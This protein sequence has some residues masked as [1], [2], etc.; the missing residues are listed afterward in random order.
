M[1]SETTPAS[2]LAEEAEDIGSNISANLTMGDIIVQRMSR[3]DLVSG[4]LAVTAATLIA[5]PGAVSAATGQALTN[6]T[7]NFNFPELA[8]GCDEDHHVAEGYDADVLISWGDAV[9]P[10]APPFDPANASPQGQARQFGYNNDFLGFIPLDGRSDHGLLVAN[11]EY[12]NAELMFPGLPEKESR[13]A[14]WERIT[15]NQVDTEMMA[16]GGSI[17]EIQRTDGKW[18]LV[19]QSKYARRITA[20]TPMRIS[21]PAAG[22]DKMKTSTDPSGASVQ[23]MLNNCSGALTPWGT[24][25]TCEENFNG[26]FWGKAQLDKAEA[27]V[28]LK[29]YGIPGEFYRWAKFHDRFDII[30]ERNE[31]N[32]FGWVVEIDPLDPTSTPIKRTA[33]GRFKHEGAGNIVNGD[34][35]FVVYQGDDERFEYVYR[36]VSKRA[37]DTSNRQA[38]RD[39]L[40]EG[41]LYVARFDA[42]GTGAWLPLVYGEGPLVAANGFAG[43]GDVLIQARFAADLL[44]A[45]KMDRPEDIDAN[46]LTGKVYVMLT[47]NNKRTAANVDAANPRADNRFGHIIEITPDGGDHGAA[48]FR[49]EILVRCGDP[50]IAAVGATF[51]PLTSTD[52]WFG[53]PDNCAF[54][55]QGRLWIATDGNAPDTTGRADGIWAMETQGA[56]RGTSKLFYRVPVGAEMCGPTFTPDLET[57]F[58]AVQHPGEGDATA[59][60]TFEKPTTRWPAASNSG[61]PPRPS[62]VAITRTGGGKIAV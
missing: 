28:A 4:L 49:W 45:T 60:S 34:G 56:S 50:A 19:P 1:T 33:L 58:V 38:N 29:R 62:V 36:F 20:E 25:L 46:P 39:I 18:S 9:L 59:P 27:P 43:Q 30:K 15:R 14:A 13:Q 11:H 12:V 16:H 37:V 54:D 7:P 10:D 48:S 41:T 51:N 5:S 40:D 21:G 26:Y 23:G 3:R 57:F 32:R 47:N 53:M 17:I 42:N 55:A 22:H 31:S 2:I 52:G 61:A 44:G 6:T 35:R 8:A 24:W